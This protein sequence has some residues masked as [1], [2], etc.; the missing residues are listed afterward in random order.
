[1]RAVIVSLVVIGCA[2]FARAE[3]KI[4]AKK[5]IGKWEPVKPQ[6]GRATV[7][8]FRDKGTFAMT[9]TQKGKSATVTGTYALDGKKLNVEMALDDM[10]LKQTM[11]IEKL[12][13]TEL[14]TKDEMGKTEAL[15]RAK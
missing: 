3:E 7:L 5:L 13:D 8:E 4:D 10:K 12:T 1:M 15:K 2:G 6:E 14:V 11:T 9:V